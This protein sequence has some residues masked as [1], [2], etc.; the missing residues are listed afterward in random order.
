MVCGEFGAP[1]LTP[2]VRGI[3]FLNAL[4]SIVAVCFGIVGCVSYTNQFDAMVATPWLLSLREG[5]TD[6]STGVKA[7]DVYVASGIR[8]YVPYTKKDGKKEIHEIKELD[9]TIRNIP[10]AVTDPIN[11]LRPK[12]PMLYKD[13]TEPSKY[14]TD[15]NAAMKVVGQPPQWQDQTERCKA[16]NKASVT[17]VTFCS[18]ALI[19][20]ALAF[21][22]HILRAFCDSSFAKD[23]AV[24]AGSGAF[25]C[26][27]VS[28]AVFGRCAR[29]SRDYATLNNA[30]GD[31][32]VGAKLVL[33]S[34]VMCALITMLT[35]CTP[36][37]DAVTD[38]AEGEMVTKV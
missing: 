15:F 26:G 6:T 37:E 16:C 3:S 25:I 27:L 38:E 12:Y 5:K 2:Y 33:G 9:L 10:K 7:D 23:V 14:E 29:A 8:S 18:F 36:V 24:V 1:S 28:Y 32:G 13:C 4:V 11:A 20:A 21:L 19:G 17:V 22:G 35:L 31:W 34:F 30:K